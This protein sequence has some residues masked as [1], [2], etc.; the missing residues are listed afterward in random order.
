VFIFRFKFLFYFFPDESFFFAHCTFYFILPSGVTNL[1]DL[2][3]SSKLHQSLLMDITSLGVCVNHAEILD[4]NSKSTDCLSDDG[5]YVE[6]IYLLPVPHEVSVVYV[7][8]YCAF[9]VL[10][11]K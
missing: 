8:Y 1:Y 4:D 10:R 7:E 2:F 9:Y 11:G 5:G 6:E 3:Y